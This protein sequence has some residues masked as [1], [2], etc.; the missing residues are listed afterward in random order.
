MEFIDIV[1]VRLGNELEKEMQTDLAANVATAYFSIY[2]F[3]ELKPVDKLSFI[4]TSSAFVPER[5]RGRCEASSFR[6]W[7]R[8]KFIRIGVCDGAAR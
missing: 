5:H 4:F 3:N 2:A 8:V 6:A 1:S 7:R